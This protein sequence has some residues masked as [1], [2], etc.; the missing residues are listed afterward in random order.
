MF[1]ATRTRF[2]AFWHSISASGRIALAARLD[3]L[4]ALLQLIRSRLL[5]K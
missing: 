2:L 5:R 3:E 1:S 4:A